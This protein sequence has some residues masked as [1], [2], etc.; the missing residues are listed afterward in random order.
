M[1]NMGMSTDFSSTVSKDL[2]GKYFHREL[3]NEV[4]TFLTKG[5][6]EKLGGVISLLDLFCM[7]NRARGTDLVSPNDLTTAVKILDKTPGSKVALKVFASGVKVIQLR[8]FDQDHFYQK[9]VDEIKRV[10]DGVTA[11]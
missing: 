4:E 2:S 7:Y 3:A 10:G 8:A 9:M 11:E 1:F 5:V 6:L